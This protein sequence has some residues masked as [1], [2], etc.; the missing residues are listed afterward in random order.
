MMQ[1][2]FWLLLL[3]TTTVTCLSPAISNWFFD[4]QAVDAGKSLE[5]AGTNNGLGNLA[6]TLDPHDGA[7]DDSNQSVA[8]T[9]IPSNSIAPFMASI[10]DCSLAPKH[11]P[12]RKQRRQDGFCQ[13]PDTSAI[14]QLQPEGNRK[15]RTQKGGNINLPTHEKKQDSSSSTPVP[16]SDDGNPCPPERHYQVCAARFS[17]VPRFSSSISLVNRPWTEGYDLNPGDQ[18]FCRLCKSASQS[19]GGILSAGDIIF[20][21]A[22]SN[23]EMNRLPTFTLYLANRASYVLCKCSGA[24]RRKFSLVYLVVPIL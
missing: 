16:T 10:D 8:D 2:L 11:N 20:D 18:K 12:R 24:I 21:F 13:S 22:K 19:Q 17:E 15:I 9:S 4:T 7:D 3:I 23:P 6:S 5:S 14:H 1:C